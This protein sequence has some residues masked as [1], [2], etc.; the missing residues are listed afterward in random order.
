MIEIKNLS[1]AFEKNFALKKLNF[2]V[3]DG[4]VFALVGSNGSGKSTRL[5]TI[6]GVYQPTAGDVLIDGKFRGGRSLFLQRNYPGQRF[7][8]SQQN[9]QRME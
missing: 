7:K 8:S 2:Q 1:K 3:G 5:R 4:S 6:S 9:L